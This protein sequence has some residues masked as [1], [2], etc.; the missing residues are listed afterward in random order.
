[1]ADD[2]VRD[3]DRNQHDRRVSD[4]ADRASTRAPEPDHL[5]AAEHAFEES[6]GFERRNSGTGAR[7]A[8]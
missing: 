6:Q 8:S 3:S 2:K 7:K 4:S 1:M 5:G